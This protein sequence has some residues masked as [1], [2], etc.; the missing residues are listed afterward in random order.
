[1]FSPPSYSLCI[2]CIWI[3]K[4]KISFVHEWGFIWHKSQ[5]QV[6]K[7]GEFILIVELHLEPHHERISPTKTG[8]NLHCSFSVRI[9]QKSNYTELM[10]RPTS[11]WTIGQKCGIRFFR[12]APKQLK[13]FISPRSRG[14]H[15]SFQVGGNR[16]L[17][18]FIQIRLSETCSDNAFTPMVA[19]ILRSPPRN[20]TVQWSWDLRI[21]SEHSLLHAC[22]FLRQLCPSGDTRVKCV[23]T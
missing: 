20:L 23:T 10:P 17:C 21:W 1:M 15:P 11:R 4:T 18:S 22:L 6:L 5:S 19:K 3:F 16:I 9:N 14:P 13:W 2:V 7:Y 8:K 12:D